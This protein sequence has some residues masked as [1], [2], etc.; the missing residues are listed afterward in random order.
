M[1]PQELYIKM[2]EGG[3]LS[4]LDR[5]SLRRSILVERNS[6]IRQR[7]QPMSVDKKKLLGIR[8]RVRDHIRN[9]T[10]GGYSPNIEKQDDSKSKNYLYK[11]L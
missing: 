10:K 8:D 11:N 9:K 5:E 6:P 4:P 1:T 3:T 7:V 2:Q